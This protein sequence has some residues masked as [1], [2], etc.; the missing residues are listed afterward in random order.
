MVLSMLV[1]K[2]ASNILS[3]VEIFLNYNLFRTVSEKFLD[4]VL[5]TDFDVSRGTF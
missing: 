5:K 2:C 4:G 3:K 1:S